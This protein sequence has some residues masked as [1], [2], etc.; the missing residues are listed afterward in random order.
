M[1]MRDFRVLLLTAYALFY[2]FFYGAMRADGVSVFEDPAMLLR[3]AIPALA[4]FWA[5]LLRNRWAGVGD[6]PQYAPALDL[7]FAIVFVLISQWL[8]SIVR[9]ELM[10]PRWIPSQGALVG[11]WFIAVVRALFPPGQ[12]V[13]NPLDFPDDH[14]WEPGVRLLIGAVLVLF[15]VA[16]VVS[17]IPRVRIAATLI[18]GGALYMLQCLRRP[19]RHTDFRRAAAWCY[20]CTVVPAAVLF[21]WGHGIYI[22]N[23]MT[24]I[25]LGAELI[26]RGTERPDVPAPAPGL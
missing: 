5:L 19:D 3:I 15:S 25:L 8:L 22:F 12:P 2:S 6:R 14:R 10:L 18:I 23:F 20:V 11:W 7:G 24:H 16:L 4:G 13:E 1:Q 21:L 26:Y 17:P 9:P